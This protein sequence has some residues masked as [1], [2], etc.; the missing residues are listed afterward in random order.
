MKIKNYTTVVPANKSVGMIEELLVH[1]GAERIHKGYANGKLSSISFSIKVGENVIPFQL[2]AKVEFIEKQLM[3]NDRYPSQTK[4]DKTRAQAER[5]AWKLIYEWVHIQAS[6]IEMKQAEFLEVF[7]PYV[8][9]HNEQRTLFEG[10]KA[11]NY[12][13]LLN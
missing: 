1:L 2:P 7:L 10:I 13:A 11:N 8:Y 5:V 12:K 4:K 3:G 9:N 6:L